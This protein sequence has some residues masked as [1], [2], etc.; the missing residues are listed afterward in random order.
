MEGLSHPGTPTPFRA[1]SRSGSG[2]SDSEEE[3]NLRP[4]GKG[5]QEV[6]C[7]VPSP[8]FMFSSAPAQTLAGAE[9]EVDE[10]VE[11]EVDDNDKHTDDL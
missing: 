8:L 10:E 9:A 4:V 3:A 5:Q 7:G 11:E 6:C 1:S 2:S